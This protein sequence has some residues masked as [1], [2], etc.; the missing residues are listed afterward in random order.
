MVT[1]K[2]TEMDPDGD[3]FG[4]SARGQI[5]FYCGK[6][7]SDPAVLWHGQTGN[8]YL[9][10]ACVDRFATA[11]YSDAGRITASEALGHP[12]YGCGPCAACRKEMSHD[13]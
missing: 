6:F 12:L 5:C 4:V 8:I 9:H 2:K 10:A 1:I 13:V 7:L 3:P 11:L